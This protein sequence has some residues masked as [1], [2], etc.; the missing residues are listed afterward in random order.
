MTG[1][2]SDWKNVNVSVPANTVT[3]VY[4]ATLSSSIGCW[5]FIDTSVQMSNS[6]TSTY[7]SWYILEI[8]LRES[9]EAAFSATEIFPNRSLTSR[10]TLTT[11]A[12][13]K[14]NQIIDIRIRSECS[15]TCEYALFRATRMF[16]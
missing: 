10:V 15:R 12:Y 7:P 3:T 16:N 6:S 13:F 11:L 14:A 1:V 9:P 2:I 5:W 8:H 4:S